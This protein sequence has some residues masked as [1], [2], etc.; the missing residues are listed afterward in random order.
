MKANWARRSLA[1]PAALILDSLAGEDLARG[2]PAGAY[3]RFLGFAEEILWADTVYGGA[4]FALVGALPPLLAGMAAQALLGD[5]GSEIVVGGAC[6]GL[7]SMRERALESA[8]ALERAAADEAG[9]PSDPAPARA[10]IEAIAT[11]FAKDVCGPLFYLNA[12]GAKGLL[13]YRA[14]EAIGAGADASSPAKVRFGR[15]PGRVGAAFGWIPSQVGAL[16]VCAAAKERTYTLYARAR[17]DA[18]SHSSFN[19]GIME[20]AFATSLEVGLDSDDLDGEGQPAGHLG[21]QV[22]PGPDEVRRAMALAERA[23]VLIAF[24]LMVADAGLWVL[25]RR[26]KRGGGRRR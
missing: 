22:A 9:F 8:S 20:A 16:A 14:A 23:A 7:Q 24:W 1:I 15:F 11:S 17:R 6:L 13:A 25:L 26:R 4:R 19:F 10:A 3:R 18:M 5:L 12:A 21:S 2:A